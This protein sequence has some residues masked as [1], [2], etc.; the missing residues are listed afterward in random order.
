M[1]QAL[2]YD[3]ASAAAVEWLSNLSPI[4]VFLGG[5]ALMLTL[6]GFGLLLFAA[7]AAS[8][9]SAPSGLDKKLQ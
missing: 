9:N 8:A 7:R 2:G 3:G 1:F 4:I 6:V 5:I